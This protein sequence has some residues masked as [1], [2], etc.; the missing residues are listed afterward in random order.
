MLEMAVWVLLPFVTFIIGWFLGVKER[1]AYDQGILL[2]GDD[3]NG[4]P[5]WTLDMHLPLE[6]VEKKKHIQ[7]R[8]M[9]RN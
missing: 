8:V 9:G 7:L 2:V 4:E 5:Y 1:K 6:E 3:V